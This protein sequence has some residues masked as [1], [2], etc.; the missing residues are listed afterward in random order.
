MACVA[1]CSLLL[2]L[3]GCA[4]GSLPLP[5]RPGLPS[6]GVPIA[7][8]GGASGKSGGRPSGGSPGLP[9]PGGMP[10]G[11]NPGVPGAG[12]PGAG[13]P[14]PGGGV[15]SVTPGGS[16]SGRGGASS[17]GD[18]STD[19][20]GGADSGADGGADGGAGGGEIG[21]SRRDGQQADEDADG[22][23]GWEVST[24]LPEVAGDAGRAG[25]NGEGEPG[26]GEAEAAGGDDALAEALGDFDEGLLRERLEAQRRGA[27]EQADS[28]RS[29]ADSGGSSSAGAAA[30]QAA[31]RPPVA[32]PTPP[33]PPLP[34]IP[35]A[36]DDD[37]VARQ[38]REAAE[39]ETDPKLKE[40]LWKEYERYKAGL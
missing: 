1:C 7:L 15:P 38:L 39:K 24:E 21:K 33:A 23:G 37:V 11:G 36:R 19:A 22:A 40:S 2:S 5:K 17:D 12:L 6:A 16:A 3:G 25:S 4:K 31:P 10:G 9:S 14:T 27:A 18:S 29:G 8:P 34:D 26:A 20:A 28:G 30:P 35:D 32:A 13:L